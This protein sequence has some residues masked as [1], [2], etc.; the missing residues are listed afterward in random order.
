MTLL[1]ETKYGLRLDV[2]NGTSFKISTSLPH[3]ELGQ[4]STKSFRDDAD[5]R[6]SEP[7]T[8]NAVITALQDPIPSALFSYQLFPEWQTSYLW[9]NEN[10][11]QEDPLGCAHVDTDEIKNRYPLL[12]P[13]YIEWHDRYEAAF[14]QQECD[15]GSGAEVFQQVDD[16]VAW[17]TEGFFIACWFALQ[18]DV[19]EVEYQPTKT[20]HLKKGRLEEEFIRFLNDMEGLLS[21]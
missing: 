11:S 15:L 14:E 7:S 1:L 19:L 10:S 13:S 8:S 12:T 4:H 17:E 3:Q 16:Q 9:C 20:Y 21:K 2:L 6:N 18:D 5:G